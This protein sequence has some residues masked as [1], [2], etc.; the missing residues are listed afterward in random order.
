MKHLTTLEAIGHSS[1]AQVRHWLERLE[2][3]VSEISDLG[4]I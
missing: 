4:F 1:A 3:E 2:H